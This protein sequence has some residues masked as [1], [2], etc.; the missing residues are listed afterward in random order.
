MQVGVL[1][2]VLGFRGSCPKQETVQA[3]DTGKHLRL[4]EVP[5]VRHCR[6][7]KREGERERRKEKLPTTLAASAAAAAWEQLKLSFFNCGGGGGG[8]GEFI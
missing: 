6:R 7:S 5:I 3:R 8:E 2:A 4:R 1:T